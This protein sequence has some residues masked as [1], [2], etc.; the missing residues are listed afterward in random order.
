MTLG[1]SR[2]LAE[3][4][5]IRHRKI[6]Q[7]FSVQLHTPSFETLYQL[8]VVKTVQARCRVN[9]HNPKTSEFT[10]SHAPVSVRKAKSALNRLARRT[11]EFSP[12]SDITLSQFHDFLPAASGFGSSFN[13]W[14]VSSSLSQK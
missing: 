2:Q 5:E 1:E 4:R 8:S 13:S 6:G 10:F 12:P 14:Q 11:V 7:Y 9:A 3:C